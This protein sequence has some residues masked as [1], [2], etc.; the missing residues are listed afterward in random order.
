MSSGELQAY[1]KV[2]MRRP[3]AGGRCTVFVGEEVGRGS[4]A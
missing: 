3:S 4:V 1:I 2:W